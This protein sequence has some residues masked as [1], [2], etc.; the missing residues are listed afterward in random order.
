MEC[1]EPK[2]VAMYPLKM[3]PIR[4][5]SG[6]ADPIHEIS[7]TVRGPV[8]NGV[9][10]DLSNGRAI[11]NQPTPQPYPSINKFAMS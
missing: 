11:D 9:S 6:I 2:N 5:P 3:F 10:C 4:A 8:C 7:S 1:L